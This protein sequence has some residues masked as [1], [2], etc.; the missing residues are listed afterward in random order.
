MAVG[1]MVPSQVDGDALE[2]NVAP[3]VRGENS[4]YGQRVFYGEGVL[5]G[6]SG[7]GGT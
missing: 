3:A 5:P 2:E 7:N 6:Q 1:D 4:R